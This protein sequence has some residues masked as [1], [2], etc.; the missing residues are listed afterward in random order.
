MKKLFQ[1]WPEGLAREGIVI[2]AFD[3]QVPFSGFM[4]SDDSL[5]LQRKTPDSMGARMMILTFEQV[6]AVKIVEIVGGKPFRELGFSGV[7]PK[8]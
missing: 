5:L 8:K 4:C 2:T 1:N 7:L 6:V 3:E